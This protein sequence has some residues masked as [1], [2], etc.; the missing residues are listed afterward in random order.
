MLFPAA[1]GVNGD[2][3]RF[4]QFCFSDQ[5]ADVK[6]FTSALSYGI[7]FFLCDCALC[8]AAKGNS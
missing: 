6:C 1:V 8:P 5:I 7:Q 3:D 2:V 4:S